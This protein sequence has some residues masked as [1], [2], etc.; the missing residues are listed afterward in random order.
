MSRH[1]LAGVG[2]VLLMAL[3]AYADEWCGIIACSIALLMIFELDMHA[4]AERED[5][6]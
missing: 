3:A 4:D 1:T 5:D 6:V 2:I